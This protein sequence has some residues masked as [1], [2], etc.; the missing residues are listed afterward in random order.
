V[1]EE[2]LGVE[3][4]EREAVPRDARDGGCR[5]RGCADVVEA[6]TGEAQFIARVE[7]VAGPEYARVGCAETEG[8]PS[9]SSAGR[10]VQQPCKAKRSVSVL[11]MKER[12]RQ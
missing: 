9:L 3:T 6:R 7:E 4:F 11:L 8:G 12:Q 1:A 10:E 5:D 2:C